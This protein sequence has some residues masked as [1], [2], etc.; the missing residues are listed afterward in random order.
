MLHQA[1]SFG[2]DVSLSLLT[3]GSETGEARVQEFID[4]AVEQGLLSSDFHLNDETIRFR[5]KRILEIT[6]KGI[7]P[8][9]KRKLHERIGKYQED[10][11]SV[12]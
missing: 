7:K 4:Q 12:V 9:Q 3:G 11:K 1:S 5:G 8:E 2:E 10:R 6:D